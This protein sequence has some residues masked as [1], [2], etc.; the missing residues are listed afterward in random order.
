MPWRVIQVAT[1]IKSLFLVTMNS[2]I[3]V[4]PFNPW[5]TLGCF[6]FGATM[7]R[8]AINIHVNLYLDRYP[9]AELLDPE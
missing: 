2:N 3:F 8:T 7:N 9:G 5:K 4:Y 6:Q 1:C